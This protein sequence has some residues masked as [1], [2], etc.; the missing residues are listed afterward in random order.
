[1]TQYDKHD[2]GQDGIVDII[3]QALPYPAGQASPAQRRRALCGGRHLHARTDCGGAHL[4]APRSA[5]ALLKTFIRDET[6][7]ASN[8]YT[9]PMIMT[10]SSV[11]PLSVMME[12]LTLNNSG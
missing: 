11:W 1:I 12:L 3:E 5:T 10:H 4:A 6:P 7:S 9:R 2:D 8:R